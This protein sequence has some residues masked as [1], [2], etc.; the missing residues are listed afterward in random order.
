ML[1]LSVSGYEASVTFRCHV[2][3]T[4]STAEESYPLKDKTGVPNLWLAALVYTC[5]FQMHIP[6]LGSVE[7][8]L[9]ENLPVNLPAN[10]LEPC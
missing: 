10:F 6:L 5:L 8:N 2:F 1:A 7:S 4:N 9:P 3:G